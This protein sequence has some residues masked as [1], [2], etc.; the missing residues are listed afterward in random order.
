MQCNVR[1]LV[2]IDFPRYDALENVRVIIN[3]RSSWTVIVTP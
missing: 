2:M 1:A 3:A